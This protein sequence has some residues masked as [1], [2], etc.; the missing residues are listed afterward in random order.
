MRR[1]M[2]GYVDRAELA[3]AVMLVARDG[4]LAELSAVGQQDRERRVPMR[5]DALFRIASQTKTIT[6][7]AVLLLYQGP[8]PAH[9]PNLAIPAGVQ[10]AEGARSGKDGTAPQLVAAEREITIRDLLTHRSRRLR[11]QRARRR[12]LSQGT[13]DLDGLSSPEV[14][15]ADN[16]SFVFSALLS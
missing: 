5:T 10:G 11:R 3:G 14:S 2:Q 8:L 13:G 1:A 7:V 9:G 6:S 16:M 15:L 4:R 12:R